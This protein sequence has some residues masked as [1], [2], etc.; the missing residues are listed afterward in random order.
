LPSVNSFLKA[1]EYAFLLLKFRLRS[2]NEL[3]L[4]LRQKKFSEDIIRDTINFLKDKNFLNDRAFAKSWVNFRLKRPFGLKRIR[5]ELRVKGLDKQ[6]IDEAISNIKENYS[7]K[8]IVSQLAKQRLER[9]KN[10]E[11]LKARQRV[12]AYLMRRGFSPE[13]VGTVVN[14]L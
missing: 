1:K 4:R 10:I 2:E 11:P 6:V 8:P 3:A 5:E 9:L 13:I 12:Y 7:E 14:A